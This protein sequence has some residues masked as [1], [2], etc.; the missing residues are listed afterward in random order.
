MGTF[1]L[2]FSGDTFNVVQHN[3]LRQWCT[4]QS[5]YPS[6]N[7]PLGDSYHGIASAMPPTAAILNGLPRC[8]RVT[9]LP[10]ID[11]RSLFFMLAI[12]TLFVSRGEHE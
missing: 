2:W 6:H 7:D 9:A 12:S 1:L 4:L 11:N 5:R 10:A 3:I 8:L